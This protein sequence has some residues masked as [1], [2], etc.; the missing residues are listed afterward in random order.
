MQTANRN[1]EPMRRNRTP[2]GRREGHGPATV[3]QAGEVP[4]FP[5]PSCG[6]PVPNA[7]EIV[8]KH[9]RFLRRLFDRQEE[10]QRSL[11]SSIHDDLA[12][13]LAG[14][15]LHLEGSQPLQVSS[16]HDESDSFRT[17]LKLLR[18]SIHDARRIAGQLRPLIYRD[19]KVKLGIEYLIYEMRGRDGPEI[20]FQ[21]KGEV[22]RL[23][24]ELGNAVFRI[25]R[26]LLA[27]ACA[28]SGSEKVQLKVARSKD[29]LRL[30][31]EDWGIGFD[32]ANVKGRAFGLQE[33]QQRATLLGGNLV[34]NS[35]PGK[36]TR[37]TVTF[38]IDNQ[39][40]EG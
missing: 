15:L 37:V 40:Y 11:V 26:E 7:A 16:A 29:C 18:D 17:G 13:Q 31:V 34:I 38:P 33:I 36:G 35:A 32:P 10:L 2:Q 3:A 27:N 4:A 19:G 9:E 8:Q 21:V 24:S 14:A 5:C 25:L 22:D 30:E 28:H 39:E 12:Q 1:A 20:V 6:R 23:P